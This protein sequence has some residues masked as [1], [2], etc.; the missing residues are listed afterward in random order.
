[1]SNASRG[2]PRALSEIL[3]ELFTVRGYGRLR[4]R[5]EL[6]DAWNAAVGEPHCRQTHVGEVRHGVLN[7]KV[8]HSTL[9]EELAGFHKAALLQA[10]R[11]TAP[12]TTIRDIRFQV[13]DVAHEANPRGAETS[14]SVARQ[15]EDRRSLPPRVRRKRGYGTRPG[16]GS[17]M[18]A[19]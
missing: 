2:G 1:M 4:A 7:V 16:R 5:Q 10:L 17:G 19:V 3:G 6:E 12:A 11:A 9:L 8:A 14:M 15:T 18:D 13:A